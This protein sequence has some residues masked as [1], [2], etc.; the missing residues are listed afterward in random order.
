VTLPRRRTPRRER[1]RT[2]VRLG[3]L[4]VVDD[5]EDGL[6]AWALM[7]RPRERVP[8]VESRVSKLLQG[9]R[10][11][12]G[13]ELAPDA[14]ELLVEALD[15]PGRVHPEDAAGEA[16][17]PEAMEVLEGE[18]G[19]AKAGATGHDAGH[20]SSTRRLAARRRE[21]MVDSPELVRPPDEVLAERGGKLERIE[22]DAAEIAGRRQA[23]LDDESLEALASHARALV[24]LPDGA[25]HLLQT[26]E[27]EVDERVRA[28]RDRPAP[29][30]QVGRQPAQLEIVDAARR[31]PDD[32]VRERR[33]PVPL[34][35]RALDERLEG[36]ERQAQ[37]A[38]AIPSREVHVVGEENEDPRI[39]DRV[40][41]DPGKRRAV[42][43]VDRVE[44]GAGPLG[45]ERRVQRL[46]VFPAGAP[47][48]RDED[49]VRHRAPDLPNPPPT[50]R[51][52]CA[53]G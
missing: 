29:L 4:D 53:N 24:K 40:A 16:S 33:L 36:R 5:V 52:G 28:G 11:M 13:I 44:E 19:L 26:R 23:R 48:V 31:Q 2:L 38:Q 6:L 34:L 15:G 18:A 49:S 37:L 50:G 30:R 14:V 9:S 39:Q 43:D 22:G 17:G 10:V 51:P 35:R 47:G 46:G 1:L 45:G 21:A 42:L 7:E 20:G 27:D 41:E 3:L 25:R 32:D 12:L 8:D